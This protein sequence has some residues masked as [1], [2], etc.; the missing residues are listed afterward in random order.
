MVIKYIIILQSIEYIYL[1]IALQI[2]LNIVTL[3]AVTFYIAHCFCI[4]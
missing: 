3:D 1:L 2:Y 4:K